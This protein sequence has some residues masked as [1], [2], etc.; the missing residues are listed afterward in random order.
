ME[1]NIFN[2]IKKRMKCQEDT[3][4]K[5]NEMIFI[6]FLRSLSMLRLKKGDMKCWNVNMPIVGNEL[7]IEPKSFWN[8]HLHEAF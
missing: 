6:L 7:S 2:S 4:K 8:D 1:K 5:D 3:A